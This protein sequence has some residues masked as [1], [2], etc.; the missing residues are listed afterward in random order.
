MFGNGE[1]KYETQKRIFVI[2]LR[3]FPRRREV[4]ESDRRSENEMENSIK[5]NLEQNC[6]V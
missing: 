4:T 6:N 3:N 2:N 1:Q 5:N